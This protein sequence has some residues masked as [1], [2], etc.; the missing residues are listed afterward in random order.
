[1]T[2][3]AA[4]LTRPIAH[5]GLHDVSAGRAENSPKAFAAA[6]DADYGIELDLQLSADGAA[7]VFHD[8]GLARLAHADGPVAQRS[9]AEL[10]GIALRHD[11]DGVPTLPQV[12]DQVAGRVPLLI[13]LKDQDGALGPDIGGLER[14]TATALAGYQGQVALMSFNPHSVALMATLC[15]DL[16]R[17]IVTSAYTPQDWPTIPAATRD[18]LRE[19]PDYDRAG[20]CFVSHEVTDLDRPRVHDLKDKGAQILCWTVK[21]AAQEAE[22]RKVAQNITFEGYLA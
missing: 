1:M 12:L 13:E 10:A 21:S 16:P 7:M 15:P 4:F 8:Y 18:A 14:A 9:A 22:A 19:I 2:L 3:P 20:C 5:R 17:G 11:G 6:I